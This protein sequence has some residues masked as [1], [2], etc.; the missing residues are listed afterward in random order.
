MQTRN[1]PSISLIFLVTFMVSFFISNRLFRADIAGWKQIISSDGFGYYAY[2]PAVFIDHDLSFKKVREREAKIMQDPRYEPSYLVKYRGHTLNKYFCGEALLLLPFFLLATIFSWISGIEISGYSFY[3]QV[4]T[5]IGAL[6]YLALGLYF[7][8]RLIQY[9]GIRPLVNG[10]VLAAILLGTNLFYYSLWRPSMSHTYSFFA[11]NGFLLAVCRGIPELR[12][13]KAIVSG[14]FLA[15]IILI[16]PTNAI[17]LLLVPFLF[18][19]FAEF[20]RFTGQVVRKKSII[21]VFILVLF[22]LVILQLLLWYLQTGRF[23]LW[24]YRNE[25]F[26]FTHPEILNVLFGYRKGLFV[27]TPLILLS[28]FGLIPLF[29]RTRLKF[30][31]MFVFLIFAIYIIASWWNWEYGDSFGLRAFI[32]FY[33]IFA[34]LLAILVNRLKFIYSNI[35]LAF[36]FL[37]FIFLNFFQTWQYKEEIIHHWAMNKLK[38]NYVFLKADPI[39]G[40]CFG[41]W[42]DMPPYSVDLSDPLRIFKNNFESVPVYSSGL[43]IRTNRLSPVPVTFYITGSFMVRDSTAGASNNALLVTS[44]DSIHQGENY[45]F[46]FPIND[47]PVNQPRLWRKCQFSILLPEILNPSARLRIYVWNRDMKLFQIDDFILNLYIDRKQKD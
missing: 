7:L 19:D 30:Y 39:Y 37:L 6:F 43:D 14:F 33:G 44:I 3:Y 17:I 11:I 25:G 8:M 5:G 10:L 42:F 22:L 38:Y 41:S 32:D 1:F 12:L 23:L 34:L 16:R 31:S 21:I 27:Y 4:F 47:I 26:R 15:I 28:L 36:I 40:K 18:N 29:F 24:P 46:G 45:W 13:N 20:K 35:V 2:L 9:L